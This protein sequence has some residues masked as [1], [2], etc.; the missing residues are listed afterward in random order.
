MSALTFAL[1]MPD[2]AGSRGSATRNR[3]ADGIAIGLALAYGALMVP[4]G[5]AVSPGA[6]VPWPVDVTIGVICAC[7]LVVRRRWPLGLALVILPFGAISVMATGAITV[8]LFTAA[9]R[10]RASVVLLLATANV[11]TSAIYFLVQGDPPYPLWVDLAMRAVVSAAAIGWGLFVQAHRRLTQSLREDAARLQS[12]Q[13]LRVEQARLTERARIAREMHDVLAH[14]MSLLS[15]YAG[16]LEVRTDAR[17][18]EVAVAATTIRTSAHAALEELRTVI[19]VLRKG[20]AGRP[21]PP[22]PGLTDV[23][24]LV[25]SARGHGMAVG[26]TCHVPKPGPPAVLGRT[27]YR[28]VQEGLTNAGK[29]APGAPVNVLL[30]GAAGADLRIRITNPCSG[31]TAAPAVPG[32]GVGLVGIE[33]RVALAGGRVEY[34]VARDLFRLEAWLP[35]PA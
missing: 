12:E 33:E 13:Q 14:R 6:A 2:A 31:R 18:E 1:L 7:A 21:E 26:Y 34:G 3:L 19:G 11:A 32:A 4:I 29:H 27:A 8:A 25:D 9:I 20:A 17:P 15:L 22:Q 5:D 24:D 28:L 10:R 35:W 23:P 16:A 30:D